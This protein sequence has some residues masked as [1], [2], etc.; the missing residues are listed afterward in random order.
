MS[1]RTI[2]ISSLS[3]FIALGANAWTEN[4]AP[5]FKSTPAKFRTLSAQSVSNYVNSAS[6][7]DESV[8]AY[9]SHGAALDLNGDKVEDYVFIVPWMGCGLNASGYDAYFIVSDGKGG[10]KEFN[11]HGY[12]IELNDLVT[13]AGK[14][15]FRLSSFFNHFEKSIHNHWVYQVFSFDKNGNMKC[16][17]TEVG[18][19]FPAV[20]I[21]YINPKFKQIDLTAAD[22]K[23][24]AAETK[25][26]ACK[27]TPKSLLERCTR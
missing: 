20:T 23:Q 27:E 14:T 8:V 4:W 22:L 17:N 12:D 1:N 15:Y 11:V 9:Y 13:V 19:P 2:L 6:G 5:E 7:D 10:R 16:A 21:F 24:I 25:P 18:K 26:K 3:L